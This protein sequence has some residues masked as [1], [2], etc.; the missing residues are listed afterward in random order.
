MRPG[1]ELRRWDQRPKSPPLS[2]SS[3]DADNSAEA[4]PT[5]WLEQWDLRAEGLASLIEADLQQPQ[6]PHPQPVQQGQ[7]A[8][9]QQGDDGQAP[10]PQQQQPEAAPQQQQQHSQQ[11]Q[12]VHDTA[13]LVAADLEH[14]R[15]VM[16]QHAGAHGAGLEAAPRLVHS[17]QVSIV[18]IRL[19]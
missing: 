5:A 12:P 17:A 2:W 1:A 14:V 8:Q 6:Q 11:H 19:M 4:T 3:A 10:A 7:A 13:A 18:C 9:A 15:V 16:L